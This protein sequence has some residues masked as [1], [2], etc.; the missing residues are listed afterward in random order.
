MAQSATANQPMP[1]LSVDIGK[2]RG[3]VD[4]VLYLGDCMRLLPDRKATV[5]FGGYDD[6]PREIWEIDRCVKICTAIMGS[7]LMPRLDRRSAW[8]LYRTAT[9]MPNHTSDDYILR[10]VDLVAG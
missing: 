5:T 7:G 2:H 6:D 3:A 8:L 4:A 10:F 9:G 1:E